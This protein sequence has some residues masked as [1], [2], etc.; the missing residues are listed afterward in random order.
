MK[1]QNG[2]KS[3]FEDLKVGGGGV[4]LVIFSAHT[5]LINTSVQ[6]LPPAP[7]PQVLIHDCGDNVFPHFLPSISIHLL[8]S[9]SQRW[10]IA[11]LRT[12]DIADTRVCGIRTVLLLRHSGVVFYLSGYFPTRE[13]TQHMQSFP[14]PGLPMWWKLHNPPACPRLHPKQLKDK[15]Q[16][17]NLEPD[18]GVEKWKS[19][20]WA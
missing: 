7:I 17:G 1:R 15:T 18:F 4:V 2:R 12:D 16:K 11:A 13:F 3:S 19:L 6:Q 9:R 20:I 14:C 10:L 5:D 8:P